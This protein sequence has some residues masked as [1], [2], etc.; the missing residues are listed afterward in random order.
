MGNLLNAENVITLSLLFP[1]L[2]FP[3][4]S[5]YAGHFCLSGGGF[6]NAT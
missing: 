6:A 2:E 1:C 5:L 3:D 4:G